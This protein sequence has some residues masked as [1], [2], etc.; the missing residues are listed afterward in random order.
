MSSHKDQIRHALNITVYVSLYTVAC[1]LILF[2]G[3]WVGIALPYQVALIAL[4]LLTWPFAIAIN[5]YRKKKEQ[6]KPGS[7]ARPGT[8]NRTPVAPLCAATT[9]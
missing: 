2:L 5:H 3:S 9:S 6:Q 8:R 7:L 1:L 4:I